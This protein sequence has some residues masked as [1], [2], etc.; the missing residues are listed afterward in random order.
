VSDEVPVVVALDGGGSKTDAVVLSLEGDLLTRRRSSGSSPQLLGLDAAVAIIDELVASVLDQAPPHRLLAV[1]AY[2]SGIDFPEE[3]AAFRAATSHLSW[4]P[5]DAE[6]WVV[7]NDL[8]AL[9]RAGT[10]SADAVAVV[11]G[12]GINALG[13]RSDGFVVRFPALGEISGDWGGGAHLGGQALWHAARSA[14]GRGPGTRLADAVPREL[15]LADMGEVIRALHFGTLPHRT[16][17]SLSPLVFTVAREGDQVARGIVDRQ[18]HEI[19]LLA[20][21]AL[22]RLG[23]IGE[24]VPVVLGGGVISG[25]DTRLIEGIVQGLAEKAPHAAPQVVTAPPLLGAALLAL[26]GV[27][28][29]PAA[30]VKARAALTEA[31]PQPVVG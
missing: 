17:A 27:G 15:G 28:A 14:D 22:R 12:T 20:E 1:H 5:G 2:L 19:V 6:K 29:G 8:F 7:D 16:V 26:E 30:L 11:C 13:V 3:A 23:L 9:L 24:A 31:V 18:A 4:L 25:S 21:A 10:E